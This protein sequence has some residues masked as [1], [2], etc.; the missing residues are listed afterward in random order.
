MLSLTHT[1]IHTHRSKTQTPPK[2]RSCPALPAPSEDTINDRAHYLFYCITKHDVTTLCIIKYAAY[3]MAFLN[4]IQ[5]Q[6]VLSLRIYRPQHKGCM[7]FFHSSPGDECLQWLPGITFH[8]PGLVEAK[9]VETGDNHIM[10][11]EKS[12]GLLPS[13]WGH[14]S[15][16][17]FTSQ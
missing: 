2:L 9:P 15:Q 16:Q 14:V 5:F 17:L 7:P 6:R 1:Y 10:A 3:K 8:N 12:L 11:A 4:L 13:R